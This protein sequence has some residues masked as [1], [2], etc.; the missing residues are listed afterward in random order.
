MRLPN[1]IILLIGATKP[2]RLAVYNESGEALEFFEIDKPLSE[3]LFSI[4]KAIDIRFN[5]VKVL[6]ARGPGSFMGLKLGY[7]FLKTFAFARDIPFLATDS[8][9]LSGDRPILAH[10]KRRFV[11]KDKRIEIEIFDAPFEESLKPPNRLDIT[12]FDD[13]TLPNYILDAA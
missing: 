1:A 11:K 7:I 6:Y 5:I 12:L 8:F 3:G 4:M 10:G 2:A 13:Q 9:N